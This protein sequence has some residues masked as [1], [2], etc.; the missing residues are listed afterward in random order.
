MGSFV[1]G[2]MFLRW[3]TEGFSEGDYFARYES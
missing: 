2:W 3:M 1:L